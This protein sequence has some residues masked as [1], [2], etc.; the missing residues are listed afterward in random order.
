MKI[1]P[2]NRAYAG[3]PREHSAIE[4]NLQFDKAEWRPEGERETKVIEANLNEQ[5]DRANNV[6]DSLGQMLHFK[7][8]KES[9]RFFVQ[10]VEAGTNKVIKTMPPEEFFDLIGRIR[11]AVGLIVDERK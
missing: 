10:I 5:L 8:H 7:Y 3:M 11:E 6:L 4:G 9:E 2:I 1:D